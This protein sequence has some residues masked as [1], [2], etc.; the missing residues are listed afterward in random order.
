MGVDPHPDPKIRGLVVNAEEAE[1]VRTIFALYDELGCLSAVMRR[2]REIGLRSKRHRFKSGHIQGGNLFSRG[3][4]YAVLRNPIYI[5]K[6]RH[7]AQVWE[8]QH[9]PIVSE[10]VWER[11]QE[12]LEAAS[13]R[14]RGRKTA[15]RQLGARPIAPLIGKLRDENGDRLTPTHT[16]RHGRQ[17]RYYVSNR[18]VSGGTDPRGWRLPAT[19]LE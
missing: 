10:A 11:V 18:L 12:K 16:R 15:A 8:G 6:I 17:I 19:A 2:A 14:P 1:T 9:E 3:Q 4:I 7:K 5:G 13:A